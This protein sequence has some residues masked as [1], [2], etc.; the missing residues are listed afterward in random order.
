[1]GVAVGSDL[2]GLWMNMDVRQLS[3]D[4]FTR[5]AAVAGASNETTPAEITPEIIAFCESLK[6]DPPIYVPA[7]SDRNG[8]YG[9]CNLGVLEKNKVDGGS[10]RFGWNV[11]EYPEVYLT[12]EFHAV[13]VSPT[14]ELIDITPKPDG[15]TR[16]VFAG[17]PNYPPEFDFTKRPN[18]CRARLYQPVD[19]GKLAQARIA[20]LSKSQIEYE[21]KRAAR[22]SLG[23]E[24]WIESRIPGDPLPGLIDAFIRDA[25][26]RETLWVPNASGIGTRCIN[27]R[28]SNELI[29]RQQ[30][31]L[32][33]I[34]KLLR[35]T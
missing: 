24:Q 10:I 1:M 23:L 7:Q 3:A 2:T 14:G 19:R 27:P 4:L 6:A 22:K 13:W 30:H 29:R 33:E 28:Q 32:R 15:E 26:E 20:S 25:D 16:I 34:E 5:A 18:N 17:D 35:R 11:W 31:N 9:F 8:M 21:N 12:A